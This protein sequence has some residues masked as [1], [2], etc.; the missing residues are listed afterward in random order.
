M[1]GH[2]TCVEA[3]GKDEKMNSEIEKSGGREDKFTPLKKQG[4]DP[5]LLCHIP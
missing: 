2:K 1:T 4:P 3:R 5:Y